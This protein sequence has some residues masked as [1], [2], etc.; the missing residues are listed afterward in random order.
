VPSMKM[1]TGKYDGTDVVVLTINTRDSR[2]EVLKFMDKKEIKAPVYLNG[3]LTAKA[4]NVAGD[5][6]FY[7]I[8]KQ[9][10]VNWGSRGYFEDFDNIIVKKIEELR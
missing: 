2:D 4:Y 10:L 9:G 1:L 3:K 8:D 6:N 5:P 7:L